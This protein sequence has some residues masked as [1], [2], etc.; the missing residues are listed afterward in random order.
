VPGEEAAADSALS[1]PRKEF[2]ERVL[3]RGLRGHAPLAVQGDPRLR[4]VLFDGLGCS[5]VV[6]DVPPAALRDVLAAADDTGGGVPGGA[7]DDG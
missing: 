1:P 2:Q 5:E 3:Y 6:G 7:A 4:F